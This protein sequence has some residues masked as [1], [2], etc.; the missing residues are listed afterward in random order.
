MFIIS[1]CI[2]NLFKISGFSAFLFCIVYAFY[3]Y[4]EILLFLSK[5]I[6]PYC[7]EPFFIFGKNGMEINGISFIFQ[8]RC[9]NCGKPNPD[10]E[11]L[12]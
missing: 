7:K 4:I 3:M 10:K 11:N 6:C 12:D 8:K 9:I 2:Y 5:N 1:I